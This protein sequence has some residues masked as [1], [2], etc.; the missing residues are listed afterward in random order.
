MSN[1]ISNLNATISTLDATAELRKNMN[2]LKKFGLSLSVAQHIDSRLIFN[3][4]HINN[5]T[6]ASDIKLNSYVFHY[7]KSYQPSHTLV[8]D[9]MLEIFCMEFHG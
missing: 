3:D 8:V 4:V 6:I 1:L 9:Y 2:Y 5:L 7:F